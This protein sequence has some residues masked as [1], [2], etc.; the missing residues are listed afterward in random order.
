MAYTRF[1]FS[2]DSEKILKPGSQATP[3]TPLLLLDPTLGK[4]NP[5]E[6]N[7]N[8]VTKYRLEILLKNILNEIRQIVYSLYGAKQISNKIFNNVLKSTQE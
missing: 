8:I 4:F 2:D 6:R 7:Q 3:R 5:R 1:S